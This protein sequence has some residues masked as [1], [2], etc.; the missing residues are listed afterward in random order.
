MPSEVD[1]K[2]EISISRML[3]AGVSLAAVVVLHRERDR[4]LVDDM[5]EQAVSPRRRRLA[6]VDLPGG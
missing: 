5:L 1:L 3:R 6:V 4:E 2:M